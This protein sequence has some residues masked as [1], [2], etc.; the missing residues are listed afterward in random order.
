MQ[1]V[2][3]IYLKSHLTLMPFRATIALIR[4]GN[5]YV[6]GYPNNR[7]HTSTQMPLQRILTFRTVDWGE[8]RTLVANSLPGAGR[9]KD[10]ALGDEDSEAYRIRHQCQEQTLT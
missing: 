2:N 5:V 10:Q 7:S 1:S 6:S 8:E 9:T 4:Y 3:S